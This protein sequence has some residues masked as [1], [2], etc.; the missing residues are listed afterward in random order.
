MPMDQSINASRTYNSGGDVRPDFV[1]A[2]R[3]SSVDVL[4]LEK[5]KLW[6]RV[7]QIVCRIEE[8]PNVGDYMRFDLCDDRMVIIRTSATEI[9]AYYNIC[10][11]RGRR[12]VDNHKGNI[13]NFYCRF[14]GWKWGLDGKL[15]GMLHREEWAQC[16][17]VNE[18]QLAL[19]EIQCNQWGGW[20]WI[21]Q[22]PQ[23]ESLISYL[24]AAAPVLKPFDLEGLRRAR[25]VELTAPVNW[26]VAIEAFNEGY[27]A[28][29]THIANLE[30]AK[31]HAPVT[32]YGPHTMY[33]TNFGERARAR[34][35]DRTWKETTSTAELLYY[36]GKELCERLK[37]LV[38]PPA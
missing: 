33:F 16:G 21:N 8:L 37:A 5:E 25:H 4:K 1:P 31:M 36:Q 12:L 27:H 32:V 23:A 2:D 15:T 11:H 18:S 17:G 19:P 35:E 14:H 29:A 20:V 28:G 13:N 38:M 6:P 34:R 30:Y 10:Q 9:K 3:Y 7:W 24:G 22:D 26:K